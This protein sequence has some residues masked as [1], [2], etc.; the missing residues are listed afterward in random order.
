[1]LRIIFL[2][3]KL[4][5]SHNNKDLSKHSLEKHEPQNEHSAKKFLLFFSLQNRGFKIQ[6]EIK[7][8]H[9]AKI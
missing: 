3:N 6:I 1:M 4:F 9:H 5:L 8:D 2:I 7:F